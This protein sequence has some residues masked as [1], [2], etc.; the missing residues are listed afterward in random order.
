MTMSTPGVLMEEMF[1]VRYGEFLFATLSDTSLTAEVWG[2]QF[3]NDCPQDL[4]DAV[5]TDLLAQERGATVAIRNGPRNWVIDTLGKDGGAPEMVLENF[6]G[7]EM[8]HI[9]TVTFPLESLQGGG[10]AESSV[11]RQTIFT[12][13][14]GRRIYELIN[15]DGVRYV[16]QALSKFVDPTMDEAALLSLGDRL[17]MPEGWRYE[18]RVLDEE[19]VCDTRYENARVLQD[20]FQ[21]SYTVC[22]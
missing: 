7:L 1:M 18:S 9:A 5:D 6:Q 17:A 21:N 12:W 22:G 3:I 14:K 4:W 15:P 10:Y 11:D 13:V 2:T 20:E 19:L 16:M 8:R